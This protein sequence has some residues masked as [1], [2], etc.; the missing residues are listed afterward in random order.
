[1]PGPDVR[2]RLALPIEVHD[3]PHGMDPNRFNW[4]YSGLHLFEIGPGAADV[5][6]LHFQGVIKTG[7]ATPAKP[8]PPCGQA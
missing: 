2:Y 3:T 8:N 1:M 4:T 5:P 6:Q 7:E